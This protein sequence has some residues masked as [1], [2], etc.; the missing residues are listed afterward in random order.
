MIKHCMYKITEWHNTRLERGVAFPK[1]RKYGGSICVG[2]TECPFV[3]KQNAII[4]K[5]WKKLKKDALK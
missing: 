2:E 4:K 5:Q 1:C 3:Q